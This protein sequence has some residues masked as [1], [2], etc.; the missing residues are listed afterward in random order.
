MCAIITIL[1]FPFNLQLRYEDRIN[2]LESQVELHAAGSQS[3]SRPHTSVTALQKELESVR[4]RNRHQLLE[5]EKENR[6]LKRRLAKAVSS[7]MDAGGGGGGKEGSGMS[8]KDLQA[9][10]SQMAL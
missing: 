9:K 1:I 7:A 10:L 5:M 2:T 8:D 4:E 6:E 3:Q